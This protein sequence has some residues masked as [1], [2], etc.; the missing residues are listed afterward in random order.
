[1]PA[2]AEIRRRVTAEIVAAL[3]RGAA[4][5]R[6]PWAGPGTAGPPA[7][8]ASGSPYSGVN[9]LLLQLAAAEQGFRSRWWGTFR[10]WQA[11]GCSV[12]Q[13][14]RDVP[15][16]RWGTKVIFFKPVTKLRRNE[17]GEEEEATF[18]VLREYTV[19]NAEQVEGA[20]ADPYRAGPQANA[21]FAGY[22]PAEEVIR[23]TGADI[24]HLEG[25][26]AVYHYPPADYIVLPL[27][28]QF[29]HGPGGL[30]SYYDT[31]FH[32]L[33]H[34]SERRLGW[35]GSY[36]LNEL[37]AEMTAA[38]T[39]AA[40]RIPTLTDLRLVQNHASYL[41]HW[42]RAMNEDPTVVFRVASAAST[43]T[44]YLL[45]FRDRARARAVVRVEQA[46]AA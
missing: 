15:P 6:K 10:Q 2:Q 29:E 34:W 4:P 23:A 39:S 42:V 31:A 7:N 19:F 30:V 32:E 12:S 18:P 44:D 25:D 43:A 5:W 37:R 13:R 17:A 45:S 11:L 46:P 33:A 21:P 3:E 41:A 35:A 20:G 28:S 26:R 40:V 16:G 8:A 14:P 9:V 24:R 27:R 1:M 38:Y 22:E 36:A